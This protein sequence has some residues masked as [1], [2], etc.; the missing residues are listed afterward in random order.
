MS[1]K[2]S[3]HPTVLLY[4]LMYKFK[5]LLTIITSAP[6]QEYNSS[7]CQVQVFWTL[8]ATYCFSSTLYFKEA[9]AFISCWKPIMYSFKLSISVIISLK[10]ASYH[11]KVLFETASRELFITRQWR[12][13]RG[14]VCFT[15]LN[16]ERGRVDKRYRDVSFFFLYFIFGQIYFQKRLSSIKII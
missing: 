4:S 5:Y 3:H 7:L 15:N 9:P 13:F 1:V 16:K 12:S 2:F 14:I 11:C 8:Y 6:F 10:R